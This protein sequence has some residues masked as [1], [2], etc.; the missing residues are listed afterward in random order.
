MNAKTNHIITRSSTGFKFCE[1]E[2]HRFLHSIR[3]NMVGKNGLF[4]KFESNDIEMRS[5]YHTIHFL[6]LDWRKS[7]NV[8]IRLPVVT[9]GHVTKMAVTP[10]DRP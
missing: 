4:K 9:S 3:F 10:C 2:N 8:R 6:Y 1:F 5:V 7:A